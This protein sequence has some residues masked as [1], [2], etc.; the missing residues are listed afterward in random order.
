M[1]S[2][3]LN[4][5]PILSITL[6]PLSLRSRLSSLYPVSSSQVPVLQFA[7]SLIGPALKRDLISDLPP[8]ISALV[9]SKL[10]GQSLCRLTCVNQTWKSLIDGG[11]SIWK[12]RLVE[13]DLWVGAGTEQIEA[14]ECL[15]TE[16]GISRTETASSSITPA[17]PPNSR[18]RTESSSNRIRPLII[19]PPPP[20]PHPLNPNTRRL[21]SSVDPYK[22]VYRKRFLTR[23]NWM[24]REPRRTS[25]QGHALTVVTCLQF[26]W[27]KMVAASDDNVV[28]SYELRSGRRLMSFV[29]HQGGVWALQFVGD[30]LVTGSTDRTVR[31]WD[32]ASGRNTHVFHGHTSTV[33]CL[34]IVEPVDL[35]PQD[36][37]RSEL[38]SE[39]QEEDRE[40]GD[41]EE[42]HLRGSTN[43]EPAYPMI[44]TGSRDYTLRVWR[45]PTPSD[46]E[47]IGYPAPGSP[48]ETGAM[49]DCS[50]SNPFHLHHLTG[51]GHAVRA[52]AAYG[53]TMVSGSY[54][55][56]VRVWD[57]LT[58]E[59]KQEMRG[60][61]QKVYSVVLDHFRSRCAS[62]SMD[63]TV[64]L[65]DLR[66]GSCLKVLGEHSSLV[67]LLGLSPNRLVSAAAD[68]TLRIW[69]PSDGISKQELRGHLGA[70]TCFSHDQF[71]VVSG[72]D[73]TLKLWNPSNGELVRDLLNGFS[74]VW[75]VGIDERYCVVAVQRGN[76][77][78]KSQEEDQDLEGLSNRLENQRH[79]Q[80]QQYTR[81]RLD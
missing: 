10:D 28:H 5:Q 81:A 39:D 25:F 65:W 50:N 55:S 20:H 41:C 52:L 71:R 61:T 6:I 51:H 2:N 72:A 7:Q 77:N 8:E 60:H 24:R 18:I 23:Q 9:L 3:T 57:I 80:Q 22:L 21:S 49:I 31:V 68:S 76:E 17:T 79:P 66:T 63:N 46:E 47:Y 38:D 58:G 75:Q 35:N 78:G 42:D 53:R 70:I 13:E 34:Q 29:G 14:Q 26:D 12:T 16:A 64:R 59:C 48:E 30:T 32:M 40:D 74:A 4:L 67:G 62:G 37:Y 27:E 36:E 19:D 43:W 45:L 56:T 33:R 44:V 11:R 54:D 73:G 1:L 15:L 69:D